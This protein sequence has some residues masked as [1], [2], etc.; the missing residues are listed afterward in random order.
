MS[1]IAVAVA[2]P[3]VL[4]ELNKAADLFKSGPLTEYV[5]VQNPNGGIR[6]VLREI[7][8]DSSSATAK[9]PTSSIP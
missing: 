6:T 1:A 5:V 3:D 4:A 8:G 2:K 9:I 7:Q